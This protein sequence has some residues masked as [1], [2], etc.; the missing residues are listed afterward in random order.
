MI[1][2]EKD[3]VRVE[4]HKDLE[5]VLQHLKDF[6]MLCINEASKVFTGDANIPLTGGRVAITL[7]KQKLVLQDEFMAWE[8][9]PERGWNLLGMI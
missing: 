6:S 4:D 2:F 7:F 5:S 9:D 8:F 1:T 3:S